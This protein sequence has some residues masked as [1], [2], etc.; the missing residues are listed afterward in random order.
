MT[1]L[2]I[3]VTFG[4]IRSQI[5]IIV[6]IIKIINYRFV[7][8]MNKLL[9]LIFHSESLKMAENYLQDNRKGLKMLV[10]FTMLI[11][12]CYTW[13]NFGNKLKLKIKIVNII[14][15][16]LTLMVSFRLSY[17]KVIMMIQFIQN[18]IDGKSNMTMVVFLLST[19]SYLFYSVK[20]IYLFI[21]LV[22][23]GK[24]LLE[25][26]NDQD[27]VISFES[28]RRI[29]LTLVIS[30]FA[31]MFINQTIYLTL[32][33]QGKDRIDNFG[34]LFLEE[35]VSYLIMENFQ[36]TMLNFVAYKCFVL[37]AKFCE[38]TEN[39]TTLSQLEAI[40]QEVLRIQY[41]A[42]R[43]DQLMT[44]VNF[45]NIMINAVNC[46]SNVSLI[47]HD[48]LR[49]HNYLIGGIIECIVE[50]FLVCYPSNR[51]CMAMT[52]L[53]NKF[54]M[55][56]LDHPD[57]CIDHCLIMRLN[58]IRDELCLSALNLYE[59]NAK[60]FLSIMSFIV[61]FSVIIMQTNIPG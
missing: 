33:A 11:G 5:I 18:K 24:K 17:D 22:F 23:R 56:E 52:K 35:F 45:Y 32:I 42:K 15:T 20:W 12:T 29:G 3:F 61:T 40:S 25:L 50:L 53:M 38:I 49:R 47:Y 51:M 16:I 10:T 30:Q 21:F 7:Q 57:H 19:V 34:E 44:N 58:A 39:F 54:E 26:L 37:E 14:V 27:V 60:T 46:V 4:N 48:G 6:I 31:F 28:E 55:L 1:Y 43:F 8:N 41:S 2:N 59:I 9:R 36:L 13:F